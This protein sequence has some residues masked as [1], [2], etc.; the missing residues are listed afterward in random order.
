MNQ[1]AIYGKG[2]IGKST[3]SSNISVRMA[4]KGCRVLQ[5][6]CDPKHD[7]TLLLLNNP[8]DTVLDVV[9]SRTDYS[10][11]DFLKEGVLG[12][13]CIEIGGPAPGVGCAGRGIIRG[14][15]AIE[16]CG[17]LDDQKYDLVI[18]D[19]L[20]DVVCG[21]FFEP[22]KK[23]RVNE[24]YIVTSGE[25]NSLFA[26]NNICKGYLNCRLAEKGIVLAGVI[27]NY[28]N[29]NRE[30][31]IV[32][33]FCSE[34]NLRLIAEISRDAHIESSTALGV[35]FVRAFPNIDSTNKIDV[36][37]QYVFMGKK[38]NLVPKPLSLEGIR[39]IITY[40]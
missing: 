33:E 12:V 28:R 27:G 31:E 30:S 7:S 29:V 38:E 3:I 20:G 8:I 32:K 40:T 17:V 14:I 15:E 21:G 35:P 10:S 13:G 18:Y 4:Q 37:C 2:G 5:I 26:A 23:N 24:I 16:E 25:F 36:I 19:V 9:T 34:V 39:S 1:I 11:T 22:L 6:G